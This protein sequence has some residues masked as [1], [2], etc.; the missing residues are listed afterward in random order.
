MW[1][2]D[3]CGVSWREVINW[4]TGWGLLLTDRSSHRSRAGNSCPPV[5]IEGCWPHRSA[6]TLPAGSRMSS[7]S[8]GSPSWTPRWD[9]PN[10]RRPHSHSPLAAPFP[11]G[12]DPTGQ[13]I[14][15]PDS[16][17]PAAWVLMDH[18]TRHLEWAHTE[19]RG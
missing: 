10:I 14:S 13:G 11:L 6:E 2:R 7:F 18:F 17:E 12:E 1:D 9:P 16:P 19:I 5:C 8:S 3:I 4:V 15:S